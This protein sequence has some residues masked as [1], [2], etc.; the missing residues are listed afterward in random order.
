MVRIDYSKTGIEKR[1]LDAIK[2][3]IAEA[4]KLVEQGGG[5]GDDFLGWVRLPENYDKE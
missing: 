3:Q 2:G 5:A 1:Q 4:K